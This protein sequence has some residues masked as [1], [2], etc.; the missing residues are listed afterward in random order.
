MNSVMIPSA[1]PTFLSTGRGGSGTRLLSL[2]L[3]Q[4]GFF[5]GNRLN[6]TQD[7]IEWVGLI[8]QMAADSLRDPHGTAPAIWRDKVY[9]R[10]QAILRASSG[11][12][13]FNWGLKLP[14]VMLVL[15]ELSAA[16]PDA[17][18]LHLVRHPL[19]CCLRRTHKTS[20]MNNPIGKATLSA[21]YR[22]LSQNRSPIDDPDHLRNAFSWC[23]QIEHLC[24]WTNNSDFEKN[25]LLEI[26]YEDLCDSTQREADR[27]AAFLGQVSR[28][29]TLEIDEARR[30]KWSDNDSRAN[31]V[32]DICGKVACQ[33][34]YEFKPHT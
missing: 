24:H 10:S 26:R 22:E 19:D 8:Y 28:P 29:V 27:I 4:L 9:A 3:Q 33:Y 1:T 31:E 30:R 7:S 17:K 6:T 20:R 16:L 25:R 13:N 15:P 14:E 23:Y 18:F 32:W 5:L 12:H 11:F 21:A 2:I 34:G